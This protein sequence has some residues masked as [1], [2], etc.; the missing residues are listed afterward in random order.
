MLIFAESLR[1][2][3]ACVIFQRHGFASSFAKYLFC[4]IYMFTSEHELQRS[5]SSAPEMPR[6]ITSLFRVFTVEARI[7]DIEVIFGMLYQK[8]FLV[9]QQ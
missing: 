3:F 8:I 7:L 9:T 4:S 6:R 1:E 2:Q 5:S